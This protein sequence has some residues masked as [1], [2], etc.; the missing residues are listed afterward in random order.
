MNNP[1]FVKQRDKYSCGYVALINMKKAF[2]HR[3]TLKDIK[4][5][6]SQLPFKEKLT[7]G[8]SF[9]QIEYL[10]KD[11]P[12][13]NKYFVGKIFNPKL[14]DL[15]HFSKLGCACIITTANERSGHYSL[16]LG[17]HS[18]EYALVNHFRNTT[19]AFVKKKKMSAILKKKKKTPY[20]EEARPVWIFSMAMK[21]INE[22]DK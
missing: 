5:Y 1:R 18:S 11:D 9:F 3:S 20:G 14:K 6:K 19:V 8:L 21:D 16:F 2:G 4:K 12:I 13:L 15:E 10:I 17:K 7:S 22:E